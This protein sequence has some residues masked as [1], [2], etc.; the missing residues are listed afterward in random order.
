MS[1][2]PRITLADGVE[3]RPLRG[4]DVPAIVEQSCDPDT[5]RFTTVPVGYGPQDAMD[6]IAAAVELWRTGR[7]VAW[8][9]EHRGRFAGLV[10][11]GLDGSTGSIGYAT[12][13][14]HRGHG[15]AAAAVAATLRWAF[16]NGAA[17]VLWVARC[18]NAASLKVA[19]RCGFVPTGVAWTPQRGSQVLCWYAAATPESFA[20]RSAA[21]R[22]EAS[23]A[24]D[25]GRAGCD[26]GGLGARR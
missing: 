7:G 17:K 14:D 15:L 3:L 23:S 2:P 24:G 13:P 4:T 10:N 8:A 9:V 5:V 21:G 12:H 1:R 11:M 6:Y 16:D 26:A 25:G 22:P 19:L 18:D 20:R